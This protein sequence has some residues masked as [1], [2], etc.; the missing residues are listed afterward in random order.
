ME[1]RSTEYRS[2]GD[3]VVGTT[4]IN[5]VAFPNVWHHPIAALWTRVVVS[6]RT[7]NGTPIRP[8]MDFPTGVPEAE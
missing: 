8:Y 6:S 1:Y 7:G 2:N 4:V 3:A 5:Y